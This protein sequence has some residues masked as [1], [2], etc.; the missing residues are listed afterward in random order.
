MNRHLSKITATLIATMT[1]APVL[2]GQKQ[3]EAPAPRPLAMA[4]TVHASTQVAD[5]SANERK[6]LTLRQ[7]LALAKQNSVQFQAVLTD[8]RVAQQDGRQALATLLPTATFNTSA[9]YTQSI[10]PGLGVKFI[11]NNAVHEYI[12]QGNVHEVLDAASM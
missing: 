9:I 6:P 3:P 8:S 7:A 10:G 5:N 12:S 1:L 2:L 4:V 11:A